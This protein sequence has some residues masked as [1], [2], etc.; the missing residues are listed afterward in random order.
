MPPRFPL[1]ALTLA[2]ASA[3]AAED[4][5]ITGL[6]GKI[7]GDVYTAPGGTFSVAIPVLPEFGGQ[8]HDTENV[9]TFDDNLNTHASIACFPL[10]VSQKWEFESRGIREYLTY[11]YATFVLPDFQNRFPGATEEA[12]LFV[13]GFLDGALLG[14]AL[15]PGGSVFEGRDTIMGPSAGAPDVAKRGNLVFVK[16]GCVYVLSMELAERVTQ[17]SVFHKTP[18]EENAMLRDRL[19]QLAGRMH[20]PPPKPATSTP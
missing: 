9:V 17:H 8:V 7:T 11:F 13:P 14:F 12:T 20:F 15:L 5:P 18:A 10:D 1:L 2:L 16:T 19:M 6:Y 4:T 3:H